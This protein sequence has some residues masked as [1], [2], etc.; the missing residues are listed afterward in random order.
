MPCSSSS[1]SSTDYDDDP[2]YRVDASDDEHDYRAVTPDVGHGAT[3]VV[4]PAHADPEV[5]VSLLCTQDDVDA[6]CRKYGV[7]KGQY[8][9]RPA[10]NLRASSPPPPGAVCVYAHALEAGMRVPLHPFYRD[11][12]AHL[13]IAPTQLAPNGWRIM[14]GFLVLCH[15]AGVPPSLAVF[16][17]FFGFL[18]LLPAKD[19][20][21][22]R[23]YFFRSRDTSGL[24]LAGLPHRNKD[25]KRGFFFLSSPEPWGC[26]VEWGQPPESSF[27]EPMLS[28]EEE[29]MAA[30][31]LQAHDAA[32]VDLRTYLC[33]S[34]LVAAMISPASPAP[35]SSCARTS[36][37]S[38]GMDPS[39][40][41]MMKTML[42]EKAAAAA[43]KVKTEPGS[44][45]FCGKKRSLDDEAN[46]EE[47]LPPSSVLPNTPP[48]AHG[49]SSSVPAG[50]CSPPPGFPRT[51]QHF[52][53]GHE[54]AST[55][56]KAARELLQGAVA[57]AQER[58]FA[59]SRPSDVV[60]SCCV[61]VLK[62]AN[63]TSFS[64]GYALELEKKL[65][66]RDAEVAALQD[67]LNRAKAKLAAVPVKGRRTRRT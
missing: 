67:Q 56:W 64:L 15:S 38:T 44:S 14:A 46:G 4:L 47:C 21:R 33:D 24:C 59:A 29:E 3:D 40:Y 51:P 41:G 53:T 45:P 34:N 36:A 39:V 61:A 43:K 57:P 28:G 54:G 20:K 1:S 37:G 49:C 58:V 10:G 65:A 16:R 31:L 22:K 52:A 9:A 66:A 35:P 11:A 13:G 23:W 7:P 63:Y 19:D 32:P 18:P 62:A 50:V 17:H 8:T 30:R 26:P 55:D 48:A 12:L 60:A 42:A 6:V 27:V 5:V 2:D 25:W